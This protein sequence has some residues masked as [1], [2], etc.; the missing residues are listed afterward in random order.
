M[1]IDEAVF[2]HDKLAE[3]RMPLGAFVVNRVHDEGG[4]VLGREALIGKLTARPE[5][6]GYSPDDVVQVAAD[7][8]RTYHEFQSLAHIDAAQLTRLRQRAPHIPLVSV[9]FFDRD[10]YDVEGLAQM[11]RYLVG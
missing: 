1:A 11:I 8:D 2:F 5:L 9:P 6:R 4:E 10:I 7:L 3:F